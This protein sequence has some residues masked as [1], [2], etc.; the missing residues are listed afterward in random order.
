M[1]SEHTL[2]DLESK[3]THMC[4]YR[5]DDWFQSPMSSTVLAEIASIHHVRRM[6]T[7]YST[8]VAFRSGIHRGPREREWT[9]HRM[10]GIG[11][12]AEIG[13]NRTL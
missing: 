13:G 6:G 3:Y 4:V 7:D 8:C 12:P 9:N 2:T 1:S 5:S 11:A 10:G